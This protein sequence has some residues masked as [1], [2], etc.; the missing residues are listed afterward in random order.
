[1]TRQRTTDE[2]LARDWFYEFDLPDGRRTTPY[3]PA[4]VASLHT[5]RLSMAVAAVA[6]TF[7]PDWAELSF[8]DL[9]CHQGWFACHV[10]RRGAGEVLAVDIRAEHLDDAVLMRDLYRLDGIRFEQRDVLSLQCAELGQFDVVLMLGLLYHVENPVGLLRIAR[11]HTSRLCLV[12]TQLAPN[13]SGSI[14]WGSHRWVKPL[15]GT[16]GIVDEADELSDSNPEASTVSISL[17][18]SLEALLFV[19]HGVGFDRVEVL[20]ADGSNEQLESGKRAMV[21]GWIGS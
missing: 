8:L 19:M 3:L 11:S 6:R 7:G 5:A 20:P 10:A 16:F 13:I 12:E 18:P 4:D 17:L 21:A 9:A 2:V 14:D 15:M 1:M